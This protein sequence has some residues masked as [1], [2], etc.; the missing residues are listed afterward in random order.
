MVVVALFRLT[1]LTDA[2]DPGSVSVAGKLMLILL[3][4]K[5]LPTLFGTPLGASV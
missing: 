4:I 3:F 5:L 2:D 1:P